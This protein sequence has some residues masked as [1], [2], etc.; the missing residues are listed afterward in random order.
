MMFVITEAPGVRSPYYKT[1]ILYS[2]STTILLDLRF[3]VFMGISFFMNI[4]EMD[5]TL[6]AIK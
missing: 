1:I 4:Y 6:N 2:A 3:K 5:S